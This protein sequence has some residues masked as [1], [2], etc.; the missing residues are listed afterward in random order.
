M[1]ISGERVREARQRRSWSAE[2]LAKHM[3]V[4]L[5]TVYR[6]EWGES[7]PPRTRAQQLAL[8]LGV[9]IDSLKVE[10]AP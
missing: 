9:S 1:V 10:L 8:V 2:Q 4:S 3:D 7:T 5:Q 6:W